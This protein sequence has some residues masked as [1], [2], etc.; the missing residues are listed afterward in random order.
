VSENEPAAEALQELAQRDVGRVSV[1]GTCAARSQRRRPAALSRAEA[2]ELAKLLT[3]GGF[4][5]DR[6]LLPE[7]LREAL[8]DD[9]P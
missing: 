5:M 9:L 6:A 1:T 8:D 4:S 3:T 7:A 2:R